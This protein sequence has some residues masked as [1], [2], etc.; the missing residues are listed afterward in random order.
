MA[1][2]DV[3]RRLYYAKVLDPALHDSEVLSSLNNKTMESIR[4][5][6]MTTF[7]KKLH[8]CDPSLGPEFL[9]INTSSL[10]YES[11]F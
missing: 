9:Q 1:I 6:H 11:N 5:E 10:Q 7:H 4:K 8:V 2:V 3:A